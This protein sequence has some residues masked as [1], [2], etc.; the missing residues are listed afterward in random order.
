[1]DSFQQN[2][3][4]VYIDNQSWLANWLRNKVGCSELASDLTQDTFIRLLTNKR[5]AT[6]DR[7][8]PRALLTH[9]AKGLVVDHWR[10][11][12]VE[13][14]YLDSLMTFSEEA[15]PGPEQRQLVIDTL[16]R[17]D[18]ILTELPELT[19]KIFLLSQLDGYRYNA[20]ATLCDVAEITVKRHMKTAFIACLSVE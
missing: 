2:I 18:Q 17:L 12:D 13:Q 3:R 15:Q 19:R 1:M 9:I 8:K 16:I 14:A 20:I 11:K 6:I 10:R 4:H 7:H 5:N